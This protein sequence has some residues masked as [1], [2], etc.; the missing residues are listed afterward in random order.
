M[1]FQFEPR[2]FA[3]DTSRLASFHESLDVPGHD[4]SMPACDRLGVPAIIFVFLGRL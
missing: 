3:L 4:V 1:A 2:D